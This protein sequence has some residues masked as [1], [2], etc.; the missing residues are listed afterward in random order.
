MKMNFETIKLEQATEHIQVL[1]IV[2]PQAMNALNAQV[3]VELEKCLDQLHAKP[4]RVLVLT[5][6]GDK[7]FVAGA[8]I[9]EMEKM[10]A[11]E[12]MEMSKR[13][14]KVMQKL[15]TLPCAT[16]AAVNGF[17]L[18]GGL[19][20]ALS[21]DILLASDKCKWGL[22]EVTLGLIP[23]YGGT[24]RLAR[25]ISLSTAQR[26]TLSG[27]MFT[28]EQGEKW[29]LFSHIFVANE[30]MASTMRIAKTISER[31]PMAVAWAKQAVQKAKDL[32]L[33]EGMRLEADLFSKTFSTQD[34]TEGVAAFIGKRAAQFQGR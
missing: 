17:A 30:L 12:A 1:K 10:S 11:A 16:I 34:K 24:Q 3:I 2:R 19:E 4:P 29:G 23:G 20:L 15:E 5:G 33:D 6:E 7:S 22:P 31:A 25:Q 13:G 18:G 14:Q 9:L 28:A 26:V 27:E 21:C 8:D 32:S